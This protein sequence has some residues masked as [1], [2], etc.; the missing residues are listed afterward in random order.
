MSTEC[1]PSAAFS[2]WHKNFRLVLPWH[3]QECDSCQLPHQVNAV[4]PQPAVFVKRFLSTTLVSSWHGQEQQW[5]T[6]PGFP[7]SCAFPTWT[8]LV[9]QRLSAAQ[10][11][12]HSGLL[13]PLQIG[14]FLL[15]SLKGIPSGLA[16]TQHATGTTWY[17]DVRAQMHLLPVPVEHWDLDRTDV[18][19]AYHL[20]PTGSPMGRDAESSVHIWWFYPE[21][22]GDL[23]IEFTRKLTAMS[24]ENHPMGTVHVNAIPW[25]HSQSAGAIASTGDTVLLHG[26]FRNVESELRARSKAKNEPPM[27]CLLM[28]Q[29]NS[30]R[31]FIVAIQPNR[32]I[33]L[34]M[35]CMLSQCASVP[36]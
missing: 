33:A 24:R 19:I 3:Y 13:V 25:K 30:V 16:Y 15:Y 29:M 7:C 4:G 31:R 14:Y 20:V 32:V 8:K 26:L 22:Q 18:P 35:N 1:V 28:A 12:Q 6:E 21:T 10:R 36:Q 23:S 9:P 27:I 34:T 11:M 2:N 17:L 5:T